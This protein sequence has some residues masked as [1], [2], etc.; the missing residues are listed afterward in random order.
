MPKKNDDDSPAVLTSGTYRHRTEETVTVWPLNDDGTPGEVPDGWD[1]PEAQRQG[2]PRRTDHIILADEAGNVVRDIH[3]NAATLR[4]G[5]AHVEHP[6]GSF[7]VVPADVH[8]L[9]LRSRERV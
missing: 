4:P 1:Y 2:E 8:D 3:G 6:D 7:S 5:E 9:Y